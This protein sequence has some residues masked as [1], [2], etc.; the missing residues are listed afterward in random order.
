VVAHASLGGAFVLNA[1][2][3]VT[4]FIRSPAGSAVTNAAYRPGTSKLVL[5]ES[6]TGSILEVDMPAVGAALYSHA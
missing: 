3:E 1:A 2:G 6:E 4:H 5:T